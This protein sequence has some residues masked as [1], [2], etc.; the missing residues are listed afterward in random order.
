MLSKPKIIEK[1]QK[2]NR[3]GRPGTTLVTK[4]IALHYTG[5]ADVE[6]WKTVSYFN[7]VVAN[8]YK[9][10]GKYVYASSHYVI[11]LDGTIF[12]L[13]P[14][15]EQCYATNSANKYAI[16][17]EVATT[18]GDNHST[19]ATYKSMVHLCAWLCQYKGLDCKTDII[20][21]TDVVGKNY[22]LCPI[23]MVKN[24]HKMTQFKND[25]ANLKAGKISLDRI[26]NC[27]APDYNSRKT[28][29][30]NTTISQLP[31][32]I[33][34]KKDVNYRNAPN[35]EDCSIAGIAKAGEVFTVVGLVERS[36][37]DMYKLKSGCYITTNRRYVEEIY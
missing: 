17:I 22:K 4:K 16:A 15:S 32:M 2:R 34:I 30:P 7:N 12:Q 21:H 24:P 20:T 28:I 36:D 1:W 27:T 29:N 37:T 31:K 3:F 18:G 11:D 14:T 8:G 23:Y 35:F 6:G 9:V 25:C 19:D 5:Q 13:I 33:R 26:V 10:N